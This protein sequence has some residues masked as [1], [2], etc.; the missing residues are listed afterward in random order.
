MPATW[1][2]SRLQAGR[3]STCTPSLKGD[4]LIWAVESRCYG[5]EPLMW[6]EG[7]RFQF[8]QSKE[9][10]HPAHVCAHYCLLVFDVKIYSMVNKSSTRTPQ[11]HY[12]PRITA[13]CSSHWRR[14]R[15]I[16]GSCGSQ[17]PLLCVCVCRSFQW[18]RG[19]AM[20]CV[21][22]RRSFRSKVPV[23]VSPSSWQYRGSGFRVLP[24][25][26]FLCASL[27]SNSPQT[28]QRRIDDLRLSKSVF[29][30]KLDDD[31][32]SQ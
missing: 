23:C 8:P 21:Y 11:F 14:R 2:P 20:S 18:D 25:P 5:G 29:D 27:S 6:L 31:D 26:H 10:R 13:S 7:R 3:C 4:G 19:V 9:I 24:N 32:A 16:C 12:R 30:M 22:W 28:F 15:D 17:V 1:D